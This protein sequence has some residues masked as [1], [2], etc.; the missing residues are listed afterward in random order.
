MGW[1]VLGEG[2]AAEFL[3]ADT[4]AAEKGLHPGAVRW[5][6]GLVWKKRGAWGSW[7]QNPRLG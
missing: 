7:G 1:R 6:R 4:G 2:C 5:G 3:A